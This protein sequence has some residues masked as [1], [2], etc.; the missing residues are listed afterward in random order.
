MLINNFSVY[1]QSLSFP[2]QNWMY[3]KKCCEFYPLKKKYAGRK[4]RIFLHTS[5]SKETTKDFGI[6]NNIFSY[7]SKI[8]E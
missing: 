4:M 7:T 5:K 3:M 6:I 2:E 1:A 8:P